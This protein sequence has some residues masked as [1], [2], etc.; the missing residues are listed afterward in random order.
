MAV[1]RDSPTDPL[2]GHQARLLLLLEALTDHAGGVR[3]MSGI[4]GFDFLLRYP[5]VL[6]RVLT[7][8]GIGIPPELSVR[9]VERRA[10]EARMLRYKYG[11]WDHRY[12]PLVGRLVAMQLVD[13]ER[14]GAPI[15]LRLSDD[16]RRATA[17]LTGY[18]W[19]LMRGR[20]G[21]IAEH[22]RMTANQLRLTIEAA[23]R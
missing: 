13:L 10:I 18:R 3:A 7:D 19:A 8:Q 9:D 4:A 12:Y 21:L 2:I 22:L 16:G 15:Q 17:K 1:V 6:E 11:F 23:L 14:V 20:C 5:V